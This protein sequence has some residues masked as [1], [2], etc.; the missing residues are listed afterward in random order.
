M[1]KLINEIKN[2]YFQFT[3]MGVNIA[4]MCLDCYSYF[5]IN[6]FNQFHIKILQVSI[7]DKLGSVI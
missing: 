2:H 7:S 1:C 6:N 3:I 5:L 4:F